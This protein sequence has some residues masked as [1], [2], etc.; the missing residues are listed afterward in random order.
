M[1]VNVVV[2]LF[3]LC[4]N[5]TD[6]RNRIDVS[7][8]LTTLHRLLNTHAHSQANDSILCWFVSWH[9]VKITQKVQMTRIKNQTISYKTGSKV[10]MDIVFFNVYY[11]ISLER[12][13]H[14]SSP[15]RARE[16]NNNSNVTE[17]KLKTI[18]RREKKQTPQWLMSSSTGIYTR[19]I[20]FQLVNF[21]SFS[22]SSFADVE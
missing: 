9:F 7:D 5:V 22:A 2:C 3:V 20:S 21:Y 12:I 19:C 16:R 1:C 8:E 15:W 6:L 13:F 10:K 11:T 14:R 18:K 4:F 17:L